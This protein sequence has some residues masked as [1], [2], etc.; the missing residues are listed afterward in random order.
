MAKLKVVSNGNTDRT[1]SGV[2]GVGFIVPEGY[3]FLDVDHQK[4]DSPL[5]QELMSAL[6]TYAEVS[7]SGNSIHFYGKCDLSKLPIDNRDS[8]NWD[9]I[10]ETEELIDCT[11]GLLTILENKMK[12]CSQETMGLQEAQGFRRYS[13]HQHVQL[14]LQ[15]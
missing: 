12:K 9:C 11:E 10:S 8:Q 5:V 3:F 7:P 15:L 13:A 14:E 2:V 1:E 6:P 4:K